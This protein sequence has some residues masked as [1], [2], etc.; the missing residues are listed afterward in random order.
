MKNIIK[1]SLVFVLSAALALSFS[2]PAKKA[3]ADTYNQV[4]NV[5]NL[6]ELTQAQE[7]IKQDTSGTGKY[8]VNITDDIRIIGGDYSTAFGFAVTR[9]KVTLDGNN[10]TMECSHG[11]GSVWV[12]GSTSELTLQNIVL[13]GDNVQA[14]GPGLVNVM[15]SAKIV[16]EDGTIIQNSIGNS[17]FGGG[18]AATNSE[19]VMNGGI[20]R[21]CGIRDGSCCYG[22][23]VG[24]NYGSTFTMNGGTI[25]ECFADG[26]WIN[27]QDTRQQAG[28]GGGVFVTGGSLFTMNGGTISNNYATHFGGGVAVAV[29]SYASENLGRMRSKVVINDGTISG[30]SAENGGGIAA[31]AYYFSNSSPFGPSSGGGNINDAG[32]YVNGGTIDSNEAYDGGGIF[33]AFVRNNS[34]V[35]NVY[36]KDATISNNQA[37]EFGAGIMANGYWTQT[38]IEG[39]TI[40]GNS[41]QEN[42][43]GIAALYTPSGG[44][45]SIKDTTITDN[46]SGEIGAGVYYDADA[47]LRISGANRIQDNTYDG[48]KNNLNILSTTKLVSVIGDLTGSKIGL[49]DPVLWGDG[50][51]DAQA[52]TAAAKLTSG[53]ITYNSELVPKDAFTSDHATWYPD[54][55]A[56]GNEVRLVQKVNNSKIKGGNIL[57][58]GLIGVTLW[59]DLDASTEAEREAYSMQFTL[60]DHTGSGEVQTAEYDS[61]KTV[62][63][64]STGDTYYGFTFEDVKA[65]QMADEITAELLQDG[66]EV[67]VEKV[68][69]VEQYAENMINKDNTKQDYKDFLRPMLN[70]GAFAQKYFNYNKSDLANKNNDMSDTVYEQTVDPKYEMST[71]GGLS[72]IA[73]KHFGMALNDGV[74]LHFE[75][76]ADS[77]VNMDEYTA[78]LNDDPNKEPMFIDDNDQPTHELVMPFTELETQGVKTYYV[79]V[80][81]IPA[82]RYDDTMTVTLYKKSDPATTFKIHFSV[83][84]YAYEIIEKDAD[85]PEGIVK[86][87]LV[88]LLKSMV[89]YNVW[90]EKY[91]NKYPGEYIRTKRVITEKA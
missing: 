23:G 15:S 48:K 51:S 33:L 54:Y 19:I 57:V 3:G 10:H 80:Y 28:M 86:E 13:S 21:N 25:T 1:K 70:Y 55:S 52:T 87:D 41:S 81:N 82:H 5:S 63:N 16:I 79:N 43:G 64:P 71:E 75:F 83:L 84:S 30:N 37:D 4:F 18:I 32:L 46:T 56:D 69:S 61:T 40:T 9:N 88:N 29:N 6:A 59:V 76:T 17:S 60:D 24:I 22:G 72:G 26:D 77:N 44:F 90:A 47:P 2:M 42:G 49:S 74:D 38:N 39:C 12:E 11:G 50:I 68:Y 67:G 34:Y 36:L 20:I 58:D 14:D 8:L 62:E 78:V 73:V 35:S 45:T 66:D 91:F 85:V 89:L 65:P 27:E 31:T 7:A 53:Y